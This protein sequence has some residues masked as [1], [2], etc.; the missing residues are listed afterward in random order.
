[1]QGNYSGGNMNYTLYFT[2]TP[3]TSAIWVLKGTVTLSGSSHKC[4][5]VGVYYP[6]T[7]TIKARF[8]PPGKGNQPG[9]WSPIDGTWNEQEKCFDLDSAL[10]GRGTCS[11]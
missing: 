10:L 11:K 6:R 4:G 5:L 3:K 7:R 8:F 2:I 1:M 9:F